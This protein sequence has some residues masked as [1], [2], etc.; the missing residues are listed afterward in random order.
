MKRVR[1]PS[2]PDRTS[3]GRE[4]GRASRPGPCTP[5]QEGSRPIRSTKSSNSKLNRPQTLPKVGWGDGVANGHQPRAE[6]DGLVAVAL[7]RQARRK[8]STN[9][10]AASRSRAHTRAG[11]VVS[12]VLTRTGVLKSRTLSMSPSLR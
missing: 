12:T 3:D 9:V 11:G 8:S 4:E 1:R 10:L 5:R 6:E 2:R 7:V